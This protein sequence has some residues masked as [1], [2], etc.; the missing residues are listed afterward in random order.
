MTTAKGAGGYRLEDLMG[1]YGD[2]LVRMFCL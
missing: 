1:R 2:A